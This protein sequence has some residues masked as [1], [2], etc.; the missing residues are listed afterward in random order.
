VIK[1]EIISLKG[2]SC[3]PIGVETYSVVM[4]VIFNAVLLCAK[5]EWKKLHA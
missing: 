2:K 4:D 5:Q 1:A 3:I